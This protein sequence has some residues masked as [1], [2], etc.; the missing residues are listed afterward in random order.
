MVGFCDDS[1]EPSG[2]KELL[3]Q[4]KI[5][6]CSSNTLHHA[7]S[8]IMPLSQ[9]LIAW[10]AHILSF[11]IFLFLDQFFSNF[12]TKIS[13]IPVSMKS[14][15]DTFVSW[16]LFKK[17][18][19]FPVF[20]TGSQICS[21]NINVYLIINIPTFITKFCQNKFHVHFEK[22]GKQVLISLPSAFPQ[23]TAPKLWG[24]FRWKSVWYTYTKFC[25]E[26]LIL[27]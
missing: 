18:I 8:F 26:V 10:P 13:I 20:C 6:N 12:A 16:Q 25:L 17:Q 3:D 7:I 5:I 24:E 2:Y 22:V 11:Y 27:V 15:V 1:E 14:N 23:I 19:W 9:I 4:M 21:V